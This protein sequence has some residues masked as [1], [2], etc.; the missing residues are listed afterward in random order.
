MDI[1][2]SRKGAIALYV[3]S[4]PFSKKSNTDT[5]MAATW[6]FDTRDCGPCFGLDFGFSHSPEDTAPFGLAT[7]NTQLRENLL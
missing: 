2:K 7:M 4:A 5:P 1:S 6:R 3:I